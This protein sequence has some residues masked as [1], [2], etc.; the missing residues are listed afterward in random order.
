MG[1]CTID[2]PLGVTKIVGDDYGIASVSILN[3]NEKISYIIPLP[4]YNFVYP[5][6]FGLIKYIH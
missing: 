4:L 3:S 6:M 2:T 1:S 5:Y